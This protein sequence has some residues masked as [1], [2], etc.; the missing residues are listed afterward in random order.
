MAES[1]IALLQPTPGTTQTEAPEPSAQ[2]G[3]ATDR[4]SEDK[5]RLLLALNAAADGLPEDRVAQISKLS[6]TRANVYLNELKT[7]GFVR[8]RLRVGQ[9]ANHWL[10]STPGK[11]YLVRHDLVA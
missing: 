3:S 4:L 11:A 8:Q 7:E 9:R 1:A 10:V 5:E 6:Q 2:T